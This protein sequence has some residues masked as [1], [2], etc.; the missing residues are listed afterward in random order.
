MASVLRDVEAPLCSRPPLA[1]VF[2]DLEELRVQRRVS[3]SS[4]LL[5]WTIPLQHSRLLVRIS[6]T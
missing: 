5:R 2:E 4:L 6:T 1:T 3:P